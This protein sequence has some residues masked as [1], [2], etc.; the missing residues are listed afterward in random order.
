MRNREPYTKKEKK[1]ETQRQDEVE[2]TT[3]LIPKKRLSHH[4]EVK[5][6]CEHS[7]SFLRSVLNVCV[8]SKTKQTLSK[9]KVHNNERKPQ[10]QK[11]RLVAVHVVEKNESLSIDGIE[12]N[13]CEDKMLPTHCPSLFS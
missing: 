5:P 4:C 3:H 13:Q 7:L 12:A 9:K 8:L 6:L 11:I 1:P 10:K 2:E